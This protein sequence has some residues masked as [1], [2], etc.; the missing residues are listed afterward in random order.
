[1]STLIVYNQTQGYDFIS[2]DD[3]S[4]VYANSHIQNG[5]TIDNI[6]WAFTAI[7]AC[8]WHPITWLSHMLDCQLYGL[9]PGRHHLTNLIFHILNALLLFF[10]LRKMTGEL[11]Q[12]AFVAALFALHPL[13]VE[14]VAWVS[15]RKNVLSTFFL[16]ITVWSYIRYVSHP[17]IYRYLFVVLF[18][19][20]GLMSKPMVVTLP[21]LLLLLDFWPLCRFRFQSSGDNPETRQKLTALRLVFEKVPLVILIVISICITIYAQQQIGAVVPLKVVS[22]KI[23]IANALISYVSYIWKMI[24]PSKLAIGYMYPSFPWWKIVGAV[25]ILISISF[26]A[27][28][29]TRRKPYFIV[30]WL[31]YLG[32]LVPVIGLVQVG[33]QSMADRYS[34]IPLIG[35]Y[36]IIA[37][38]VPELLEN[39]RHKKIWFSALAIVTL[40]IF[41]AITWKQI[42]YWKNTITIFSKA[43]RVGSDNYI[44]HYHL[45][46]TLFYQGHVKEAI[47][48]FQEALKIDPTQAS[49]NYYMGL[50]LSSQGNFQEAIPYF[51]EAVRSEPTC[52]VCRINLSIALK[53]QRLINQEKEH[54]PPA[55]NINSMQT[56]SH[57]LQENRD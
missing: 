33:P 55:S 27:I 3:G 28:K 18:F 8:N 34:Y 49:D 31:W 19:V 9:N 25:L 30:G 5:L 35:I 16:L 13:N 1:M 51:Q 57:N 38:G 11:W 20:F 10:L 26:L 53:H 56:P 44:A 36:I 2:Y 50:A 47:Y 43:L 15:E 4:Y 39:W 23:R 29:T 32:T 40:S 48:H 6:R 45:G 46:K 42:G 37:W 21:C 17:A 24:F 41:T 7:N 52:E 22:L 12:S 14:S 54:R